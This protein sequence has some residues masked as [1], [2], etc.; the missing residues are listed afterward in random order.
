MMSSLVGFLLKRLYRTTTRGAGADHTNKTTTTRKL[1]FR[2][3]TELYTYIRG[4]C[5]GLVNKDHDHPNRGFA[6][7]CIYFAGRSLSSPVLRGHCWCSPSSLLFE[8]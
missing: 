1:S 6:L 4:P 5:L 7:L 2:T 8:G 3:E